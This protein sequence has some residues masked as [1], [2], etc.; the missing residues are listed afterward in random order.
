MKRA[1]FD[2][3]IEAYRNH[4]ISEDKFKE[5]MIEEIK[6]VIDEVIKE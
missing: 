5:D 6:N 2:A 1:V 4:A 3:I